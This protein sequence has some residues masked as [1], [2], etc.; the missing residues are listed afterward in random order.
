MKRSVVGFLLG[1]GLATPLFGQQKALLPQMIADVN[2]TSDTTVNVTLQAGLRLS[3][4]IRGSFQGVPLIFVRSTGGDLLVSKFDSAEKR[5]L[6]IVP[7]GTYQLGACFELQSGLAQ[8]RIDVPFS[9]SSPL[10]VLADTILD[11]TLTGEA[12]FPISGV[13]QGLDSIS[14]LS[15][16]TVVFSSPDGRRGGTFLLRS[17]GAY[18]GRL[19]SGT[20]HASLTGRIPVGPARQHVLQI[21]NVGSVVVGGLA[22]TA[23]FSVPAT[24]RI[25]GKIG[26]SGLPEWFSGLTVTASDMSAPAA[27]AN[28]IRCAVVPATSSFP[29][30]PLAGTYQ[31][32][33][34]NNRAHQMLLSAEL[35][36]EGKP[37]GTLE[38]PHPRPEIKPATSTTYN[39]DMQL[40]PRRVAI[41][42]RVADPSGR[43][44]AN[45]A[46]VA[47][48]RMLPGTTACFTSTRV[49]TDADGNY[50]VSVISGLN[51]KIEFVPPAPEP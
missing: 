37:A 50:R 34:P 28:E 41:T 4:K 27:P 17:D 19:A 46:V 12:T 45:T 35:L 42:G 47:S 18:Q 32:V 8:G 36:E 3:G 6:I 39:F 33:V 25:S 9:D 44:V 5:Y 49:Q 13:V 31:M 26:R 10:Q 29:A 16:A 40:P 20:Y 43:G 24:A 51:Y 30:D 2:A 1:C 7:P 14:S 23:N 15:D 22:T 38:F 11:V 21:F 48:S